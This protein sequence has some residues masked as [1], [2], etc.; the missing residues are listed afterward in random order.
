[1]NVTEVMNLLFEYG[2][3]FPYKTT[4]DTL[5]IGSDEKNVKK[6][7]VAMMPTVD[8]IKQVI[9]WGADLFVVHEPIYFNHPDN[10][11]S[12]KIVRAKYKMLSDSGMA[13]YRFHDHP[14]RN[15][16]DMIAYGALDKLGLKGE[17]NYNTGI[18]DLVDVCL[19]ES[20]T[21]YELAK[22][23]EEKLGLKHVR[24]C[25]VRDVPCKH[26]STCMGSPG[27]IFYIA[28]RE[29]TEIIIV[30]EIC[31]WNNG[32]YIRD[33]AALGFTKSLLI[34]GHVG[35]ERSGMMHIADC[36]KEKAPEL[37]V[38]YFETPELYTYTDSEV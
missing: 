13:V 25:G 16:K 28:S 14:H 7:A 37:E 1:M 31:E 20:I 12:D 38:K 19:E 24:I 5:K 8:I 17:Y 36:L 3:D 22:L 33:C 4:C 21:P 35:S 9:G 27:D 11:N 23:I 30:G 29:N 18:F 2:E 10:L 15:S 26:I 32:E 34:L 6:V